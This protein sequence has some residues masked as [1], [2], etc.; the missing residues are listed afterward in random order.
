SAFLD[1]TFADPKRDSFAT[2]TPCTSMHSSTERGRHC[3]SLDSDRL[4]NN[5]TSVVDEIC[6]SRGIRM[7][8]DIRTEFSV[9][10]WS[11][12]NGRNGETDG[13]NDDPP[14][15]SGGPNKVRQSQRLRILA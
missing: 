14:K 5:E 15:K 2:R 12:W 8:V 1:H 10:T 9:V 7:L 13:R 6:D 4:A 3:Q 11:N